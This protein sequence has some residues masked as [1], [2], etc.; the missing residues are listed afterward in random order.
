[1]RKGFVAGH[2]RSLMR[3]IFGF[4]S[5]RAERSN[6]A[7]K[8]KDCFAPLAMTIFGRPDLMDYCLPTFLLS[9]LFSLRIIGFLPF[10]LAPRLLRLLLFRLDLIA[11]GNA[12]TNVEHHLIPL[13]NS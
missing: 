13:R 9:R 1:M 4:V 3:E 8:G 11:L 5:L 10:S 6:L 7:L 12:L 2:I